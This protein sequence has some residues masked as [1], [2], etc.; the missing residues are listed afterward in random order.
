MT[1]KENLII[2]S[3]SEMPLKLFEAADSTP[4]K[5]KYLFQGVFTECSTPDHVVINRNQRSYPLK[6]CAS[7][8]AY[9]REQIK[10]SGFILGELDHPSDGRFDTSLKQASHAILDI[11]VDFDKAVVEGKL[12]I[13]DTPNGQIAKTLIDAGYPLYVSS[14]AAGSVGNDKNHTVKID[15]LFTYDIVCVPGFANARLHRIDESVQ[16]KSAVD[17]YLT[18]SA[19]YQKT[20]SEY[21][22]SLGLNSDYIICESVG[23]IPELSPKAKSILENG[24]DEAELSKPIN[25]KDE[26]VELPTPSMNPNDDEKKEDDNDNKNLTDDEK[27][28]KRN[29]ILGVEA[30]AAGEESSEADKEEKRAEILDVEA[31]EGDEDITEEGEDEK[32]EDKKEETSECDNAEQKAEEETEDPTDIKTKDKKDNDKDIKKK[33]LNDKEKAGDVADECSSQKDK[34]AAL[35]DK[36]KKVSEVKESIVRNY[37]FSISLSDENFAKFA[38]LKPGDKNKVQKFILEHGVYDIQRINNIWATPLLEEKRSLKNWLRLATDEDKRLFAAAP[39]EVQDAIE[40]SAK[41]VVIQTADDCNRFWEKTGLRQHNADRILRESMKD[42]YSL[43]KSGN[44]NE[45]VSYNKEAAESLGY[46]VNYFKMLEDT[47]E[48]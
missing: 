28:E 30:I 19:N 11:W 17:T 43:K 40:E 38:A 3:R 31:V 14:R 4:D 37:P 6:E 27:S 16:Y 44:L 35:L 21:T 2:K 15:Q 48:N 25:E 5:P 20:Q 36:V 9:L 45:N 34:V 46:S 8:I 23:N 18:E 39:M 7:H 24:Y 26:D 42:R 47:Y 22:K 41:Y 29:L 32:K 10:E 13:L 1:N 12:Q 33:V